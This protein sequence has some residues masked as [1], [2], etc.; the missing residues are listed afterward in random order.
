M[1]EVSPFPSEEGVRLEEDEGVVK[2]VILAALLR[3]TSYSP[4]S[5]RRA[6]SN[7]TL[8]ELLQNLTNQLRVDLDST[9]PTL[10]STANYGSRLVVDRLSSYKGG[11]I[12]ITT[13]D[14]DNVL[15]EHI[16]YI[17]NSTERSINTV[18]TEPD[19]VITT[20]LPFI[21]GLNANQS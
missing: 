15:A 20:V 8:P 9:L 16:E 19:D 5:I 14:I 17:I 18:Q 21:I 1:A 3:L 2:G 11:D 4:S 6:Y 13:D 10:T 12:N 7:N